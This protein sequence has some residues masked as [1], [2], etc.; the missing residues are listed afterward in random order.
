[1][2]EPTDIRL[3]LPRADRKRIAADIN[4]EGKELAKDI[5]LHLRSLRSDLSLYAETYL[6][7]DDSQHTAA[8]L[9]WLAD[10]V[11]ELTRL[12]REYRVLTHDVPW[13]ELLTFR[14]KPLS[15]S[16]VRDDD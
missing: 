2:S 3:A 13:R 8:R 9:R 4:R 11:D 6:S 14:G 5:R 7:D 15:R 10:Q 1:M 16:R 12:G